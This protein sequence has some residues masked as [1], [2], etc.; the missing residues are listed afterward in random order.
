MRLR[1]YGDC[2][3]R[4]KS[5][6]CEINKNSVEFARKMLEIMYES[7][8]VGLAAPQAGKNLR[9]VV[10]DI[11]S[12]E[13]PLIM[14]NPVIYWLSD[15]LEIYEEGCL[16]FPDITAEIKR[17]AQAAYFFFDEHNNRIDRR[18][19]GLEARAIQHEIDHLNG[20]LLIDHV[21]I[22]KRHLLKKKL[23]EIKKKA[24]S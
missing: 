23:A 9:I 10:I 3:L 4:E 2:V 8:G 15:E 21:G 22:A 16:S 17:P 18:V 12:G 19:S 13:G 20:T 24:L 7:K 11:Q 6:D 1:F 5:V 14:F